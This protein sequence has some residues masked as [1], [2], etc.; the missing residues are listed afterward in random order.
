M[1]S[2]RINIANKFSGDIY[3]NYTTLRD[4]N[5]KISIDQNSFIQ[6]NNVLPKTVFYNELFISM[7]KANLNIVSNYI[8]K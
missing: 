2:Y 3:D 6:L 7:G 8:H 5:T 1:I 4:T